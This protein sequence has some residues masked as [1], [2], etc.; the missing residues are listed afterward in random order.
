[1]NKYI[2]DICRAENEMHYEYCKNCG[3]KLEKN[4]NHEDRPQ[5]ENQP[6]KANSTPT[7]PYTHSQH[8]NYSKG[9]QTSYDQNKTQE[10]IM[11]KTYGI[12]EIDGVK[13]EDLAA[14]IGPKNERIINKFSKMELTGSKVSWC[15][16]ASAWGLLGPIGVALWF[17]YRKMYKLGIIILA[18]GILLNTTATVIAG[19]GT[20]SIT[21]FYTD[22]F[23][24]Y[25]EPEESVL[26]EIP[27]IEEGKKDNAYSTF[28]ADIAVIF[29]DTIMISS[30]ILAGL[31]SMYAY[32]K[33]TI[34]KIKRYNI[35]NSTQMYHQLG[36][37]SVG[38]TAVGMAILA[39]LLAVVVS[40]TINDILFLFI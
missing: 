1:M 38:G 37:M 19:N 8:D 25:E 20:S 11:Q 23:G 16:P 3:N 21:G 13:A 33:H 29:K 6:I 14:Y 35:V 32:K 28:R 4:A 40:I 10:P 31:F 34:K 26:E 7:S 15:W 39:F 36:L 30:V 18:I 12:T 5:P 22:I 2:C 9:E 24:G 17:M 27:E